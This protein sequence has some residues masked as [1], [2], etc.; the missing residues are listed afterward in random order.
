MSN[1][2]L[3]KRKAVKFKIPN[4][5]I[6]RTDSFDIREKIVNMMP[7]ERRELGINKSTHWYQKRNITAGKRV[8]VYNKVLSK[9]R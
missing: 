2:V 3:G 5:Q 7:Y 4:V 9:L 6:A 1:F 8:R